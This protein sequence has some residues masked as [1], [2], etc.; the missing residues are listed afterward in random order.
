MFL[1]SPFEEDD[2]KSLANN[3]AGTSFSLP[4]LDKIMRTEVAPILSSNLIC[5]AGQWG[6]WHR[7]EEVVQPIT[8]HLNAVR[9]SPHRGWPIFR[10]LFEMFYMMD[11][12]KEWVDILARVTIIR[13]N[14]G[15]VH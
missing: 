13:G 3:L 4:E 6:C 15:S 2:K 9:N 7:E 1:D 10:K 5:V 14:A 11:V 8:A 12:Q